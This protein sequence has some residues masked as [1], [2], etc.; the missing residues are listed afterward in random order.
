MSTQNDCNSIKRDQKST[1]IESEI[2]NRKK[3]GELLIGTIQYCDNIAQEDKET[4]IND[5]KRMMYDL[6]YAKRVQ[7]PMLDDILKDSLPANVLLFHAFKWNRSEPCKTDP[8]FY[9]DMAANMYQND[10]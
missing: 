6:K 10:Y 8:N 3:I 9:M 1:Q 4:A 7:F 5:I 2:L